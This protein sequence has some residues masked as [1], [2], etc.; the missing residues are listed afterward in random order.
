MFTLRKLLAE[1]ANLTSPPD[2]TFTP[3]G[4]TQQ[5]LDRLVA[6]WVGIVPSCLDL[7]HF[8]GDQHPVAVPAITCCQTR[9]ATQLRMR[10]C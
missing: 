3:A 2:Y 6:G 8:L 9:E 5:R 1:K 7:V 4:G 10:V